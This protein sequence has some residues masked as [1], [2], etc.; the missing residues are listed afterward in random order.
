MHICI[1]GAAKKNTP[2]PKMRFLSNRSRLLRQILYT[3]LEPFCPR[4][5]RFSLI[6]HYIQKIG[7]MSNLKFKFCNSTTFDSGKQMLHQLIAQSFVANINRGTL[8]I[9]QLT[10][11]VFEMPT[12]CTYTRIQSFS[13]AY[14]SSADSFI[15]QVVSDCLQCYPQLRSFLWFWT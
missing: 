6:S 10:N 12:A 8:A 7:T 9:K 4:F 11:G 3:G 13:K 2:P 15:R 5:C 1:Q 14:D